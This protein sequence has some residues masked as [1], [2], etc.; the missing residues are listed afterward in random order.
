[1]F[2]DVELGC[3]TSLPSGRAIYTLSPMDIRLGHAT[4]FSQWDVRSFDR[5]K[6]LTYAYMV[7]L[8]L[9][10]LLLSQKLLTY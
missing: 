2:W 8:A 6:S 9:F 1:M 3:E 4:C 5:S 7:H 10:V